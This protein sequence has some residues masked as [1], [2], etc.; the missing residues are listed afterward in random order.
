[1]NYFAK[2]GTPFHCMTG[3]NYL[4]IKGSHPQKSSPTLSYLFGLL[5]SIHF[6]KCGNG[7]HIWS[8]QLLGIH[9]IGRR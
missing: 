7:H 4:I 9:C 6:G 2:C 5:P 1:M 3:S 8:Y